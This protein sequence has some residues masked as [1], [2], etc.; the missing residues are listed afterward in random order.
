MLYERDSS[1]NMLANT[2]ELQMNECQEQIR[3][4]VL[5]EK[6]QRLRLQRKQVEQT[7]SESP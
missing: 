4:C 5:Y 6:E 7:S 3:T 1:E 2:S